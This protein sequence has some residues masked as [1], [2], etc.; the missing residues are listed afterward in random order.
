M[1]RLIVPGALPSISTSRGCT[2]TASAIAGFVTAMRVMSNSVASTVD[3]PAVSTTRSKT[4]WAAAEPVATDAGAGGSA[5]GCCAAGGGAGAGCCAR[6]GVPATARPNTRAARPIR[7]D[8][9][10]TV[11]STNCLLSALRGSNCLD[12]VDA[13]HGLYLDLRSGSRCAPG[14]RGA[15]RLIGARRGDPGKSEPRPTPVLSVG[16]WSSGLRSVSM[17][18]PSSAASVR[19]SASAGDT[20]SVTTLVGIGLASF[21]A[22]SWSNRVPAVSTCTLLTTTRDTDSWLSPWLMETRTSTRV[23]GTTKPATPIT[24]LTFS[25]IARIPGGMVGGR[26]AP[27]PSFA[28]L[29]SVSGSF[30]ATE[31]MR[32]RLTTWSTRVYAPGIMLAAGQGMTLTSLGPIIVPTGSACA[33]TTVRDCAAWA[34]RCGIART[35]R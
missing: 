24:S 4:G 19:R 28:T 6:I 29:E 1:I 18:L 21:R 20:S 31:S 17:I 16:S 7:P 35:A 27:A 10:G 32:P 23:P 13:R 26:P 14:H 22:R 30:S 33:A 11:G 3:R 15:H 5:E 25:E 12:L 9:T 34:E 2:T 8:R